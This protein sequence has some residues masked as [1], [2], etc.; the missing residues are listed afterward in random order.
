MSPRVSCAWMMSIAAEVKL[1]AY[2]TEVVMAVIARRQGR[3]LPAIVPLM[4]IGPRELVPTP[5]VTRVYN[6]GGYYNCRSKGTPTLEPMHP[7]L[8]GANDATCAS[9]ADA[10][11]APPSKEAPLR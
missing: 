10:C 5:E 3:K 8:S 6:S 11:F 7:I 2:Q 4:E 1:I 9:N